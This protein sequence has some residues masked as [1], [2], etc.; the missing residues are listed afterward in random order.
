[1]L[2]V[3]KELPEPSR[4]CTDRRVTFAE[5]VQ[6]TA[7]AIVTERPGD[8]L[9]SPPL[10]HSGQDVVSVLLGVQRIDIGVPDD[11]QHFVRWIEAGKSFTL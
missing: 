3:Q 10:Q 8:V 6:E 5:E 9:K 2:R 1:M 7:F 11:Y 4:A